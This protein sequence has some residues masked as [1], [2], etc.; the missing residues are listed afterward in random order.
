MSVITFTPYF[1][2]QCIWSNAV[3]GLGNRSRK[4]ITGTLPAEHTP[5][6]V[7]SRC[8]HRCISNLVMTI[9]LLT[10]CGILLRLLISA[11]SVGVYYC[12][13][14]TLSVCPDV[15]MSVFHAPSN[16]FFFFVSRWNQAIF[17]LSVLQVAL[18]KTLFLD[19]WFRPLTPKICS[20]KFAQNR[21]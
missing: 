3:K 20:P 17:W 19:F 7:W 4:P 10:R 6:E 9:L 18:Y 5:T 12:Q 8:D 13:Q 16:C 21:L 14:L 2:F 11:P 15:R 1:Y